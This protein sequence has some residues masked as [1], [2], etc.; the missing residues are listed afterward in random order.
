MKKI[1][2]IPI[3]RPT[4]EPFAAYASLFKAAIES[5]MLTSAGNVR[6][7][8]RRAAEY[9]GV[10]Y[11]VAL[12]SCT[13]GL[14]LVCKGL[15]LMGEVILPSFTFSASA[16][17]LVWN[18]LTPVYADIDPVTYTVDP[19]EVEKLITKNTSAIL[20]THVF[21][22]PANVAKL[23]AI[24][25]KHNLKLIFDAAHAFGSTIDGKKVGGF[26]DAEVFSCSSTKVLTTG[27]GGIVAT[28]NEA[29]ATFVRQGRNYGDDGSGDPSFA[30]LSAR[31]PDL[32]AAVGLRSL[33]KL[34]SNLKR[35][36]AAA[37]YLTN[38]LLKVEPRLHFQTV[39]ANVETT[40]KDLSVHV[41]SHVLGY[42]RDELYDFFAS[43]DIVTRKYFYPPLHQ[44][45]AY[46]KY[47][48]ATRSLPVTEYVASGVLSLPMYAHLAKA[49]MDLITKTFNEFSHAR[50]KD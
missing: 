4:L 8:E 12:S 44:M 46:K 40:F 36:R 31:M 18:N 48:A 7:F 11:C 10:K 23:S 34:D 30:G 21:G 29:L 32:S 6:E 9:L 17:P 28:N 25:R 43:R 50:K 49:D 22:I 3:T 41:N 37:R 27:E 38:G 26:G 2:N 14:M 16:L 5:G 45:R 47:H 35:R 1:S 13:A 33:K 42:T 39:P 20:A 24:A 19:A 15:G